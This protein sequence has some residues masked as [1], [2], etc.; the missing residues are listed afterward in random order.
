MGA[1][2]YAS[3]QKAATATSIHSSADMLSPQELRRWNPVPWRWNVKNTKKGSGASGRRQFEAHGKIH[4]VH[5]LGEGA[6][7]D[8]VHPGLGH[9]PDLGEVYATGGFQLGAAGGAPHGLAH[10]GEIEVVQQQD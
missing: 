2:K 4:G 1:A 5:V 8:V 10:A 3:A 9:G 7:R 6:D